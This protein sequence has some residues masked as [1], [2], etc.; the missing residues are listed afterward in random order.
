MHWFV[1]HGDAMMSRTHL[2]ELVQTLPLSSMFFVKKMIIFRKRF[3]VKI[4]ANYSIIGMWRLYKNR[5]PWPLIK[6]IYNIN[7]LPHFVHKDFFGTSHILRNVTK[8]F[9]LCFFR[10]STQQKHQLNST[11]LHSQKHQGTQPLPASTRSARDSVSE[12]NR[13]LFLGVV[14]GFSTHRPTYKGICNRAIYRCYKLNLWI[15]GTH[16]QWDVCVV[17]RWLVAFFT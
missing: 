4:W 12:H 2:N 5:L 13:R 14:G 17:Q 15:V 9:P 6:W 11:H 3:E 7:E 8:K 1:R 10:G 16:L